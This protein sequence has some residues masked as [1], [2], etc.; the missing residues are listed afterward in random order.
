MVLA[1]LSL[2]LMF[3]DHRRHLAEPVR[4]ALALATYPVQV[5]V[6]LP[7]ELAALL[8]E[9]LTTR[10]RLIEENA[11]LHTE[12][13]LYQ[14]RL[15]RLD[16]LERENINLR[17]LLQSSYEV[18]ESVL[19]AELMRVDLDPAVHLIQIDKGTRAGVYAGQPVLDA[20]GIVGQ[21]DRTTPFTAVVRLVTDPSHAIP[22]QINRNGIR[23]I[24][25]GT[26][27]TSRLELVNVPSNADVQPGDLLVSS[28]LG[29]RFPPGY[30]VGHVMRVEVDPGRPFARISAEPTAALDRSREFLLVRSSIPGAPAAEVPAPVPASTA[31]P[32]AGG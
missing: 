19:I 27:D 6:D 21:V 4:E 3:L 12:Q 11:R 2:A 28:G 30:P 17:Q 22:V 15:Q 26:G 5:A 1:L 24:A 25:Y 8:S 20:H 32:G 16:A 13:L 9:Q 29:E 31:A 10:R 7:F 14:A 23:A 18:T